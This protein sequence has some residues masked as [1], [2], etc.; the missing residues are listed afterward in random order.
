MSFV[1]CCFCSFCLVSLLFCFPSN[2]KPK[3]NRLDYVQSIG[4]IVLPCVSMFWLASLCFL[5]FVCCYSLDLSCCGCSL[6]FLLIPMMCFMHL[7]ICFLFL[8]SNI[9]EFGQVNGGYHRFMYV[10]MHAVYLSL[11]VCLCVSLSLYIYIHIHMYTSWFYYSDPH[12][13]STTILQD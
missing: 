7:L 11:S 12:I 3:N 9:K 10:C 6:K 4:P 13:A 1:E 2:Q 8:P 5:F